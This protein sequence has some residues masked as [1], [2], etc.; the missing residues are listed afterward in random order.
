MQHYPPSLLN[1]VK[2]LAKLP[3]IGTKSAERLALHILR[4]SRRDAEL[5]A[6]AILEVK[7][8]SRFCRLCFN[9][10][11][12]DLCRICGDPTRRADLLCVVEQP[13]D[14]ASIEKTGSFR[15]RYHI[16]QGL[17][18]PINGIGPD[19]IRIRELIGRVSG[20]EGCE[21]ILATGTTVEGEATAA[22]IAEKL[23]PY[24]V[25]VT[26]IACGVPVGGELKYVDQV[27]LKIALQSRREVGSDE[28]R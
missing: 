3:G 26:R 21:V 1:L 12:D 27:T 5:L 16:L 25:R 11:D 17:L 24:P 2:Q 14:L 23:A 4:G 9:F 15:G 10:S 20:R 6:A 22:Y 8:K 13:V 18:S 19:Q 7:Q 28:S